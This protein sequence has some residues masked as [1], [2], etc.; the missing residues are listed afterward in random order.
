[1]KAQAQITR[2]SC[3]GKLWADDNSDIAME[4]AARDKEVR[5]FRAWQ[6][7]W[8]KKKLGPTGDKV[9]EAR[10]LKNMQES[11]C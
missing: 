11:S 9:S 6:E 2:M 8:E 5:N 3:D 10:L 1:M 7:Q 4:R